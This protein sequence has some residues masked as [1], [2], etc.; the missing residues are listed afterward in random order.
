MRTRVVSLFKDDAH[1]MALV[2]LIET[3]DVRN[4]VRCGTSMNYKDRIGQGDEAMDARYIDASG[5]R[6]SF[7]LLVVSGEWCARW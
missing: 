5:K 1:R 4:G 2:P 6:V 7:T 3:S